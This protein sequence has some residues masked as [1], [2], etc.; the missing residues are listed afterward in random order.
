LLVNRCLVIYFSD[1][2]PEWLENWK[3]KKLM[4]EIFFPVKIAS[5]LA[6]GYPS[7]LG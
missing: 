7:T 3:S 1:I 6:A 4:K 5:V 2:D